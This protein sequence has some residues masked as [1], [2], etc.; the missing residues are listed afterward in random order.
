MTRR[1][2]SLA[3]GAGHSLPR[4][5][6]CA[7]PP[8]PLA[9]WHLSDRPGARDK[10]GRA[11]GAIAFAPALAPAATAMSCAPPTRRPAALLAAAPGGSGAPEAAASRRARRSREHGDRPRQKRRAGLPRS[12]R[13]RCRRAGI[14]ARPLRPPARRLA[15][16][17]RS[18]VGVQS[19]AVTLAEKIAAAAQGGGDRGGGDGAAAT[20]LRKRRGR[21][22]RR[23]G[24]RCGGRRGGVARGAGAAGSVRSV[25]LE[26][27]AREA[28]RAFASLLRDVPASSRS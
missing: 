18:A 16:A 20:R 28:A 6:S 9:A 1:L 10:R 27:A 5:P 19:E 14:A 3:T 8:R 13:R 23:R 25:Q 11:T 12:R 4:G 22:Q 15:P 2:A 24:G 26:G 17:P 21:R 7:P